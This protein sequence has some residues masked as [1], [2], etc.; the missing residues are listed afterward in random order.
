MENKSNVIPLLFESDSLVR[1]VM[2][3]GEI[4]FVAA[5]ICRVLGIQNVSQAVSRLNAHEVTALCTNEG[6]P[7]PAANIVS[8]PGVYRLVFTSRKPV[9]ER[10][11][12][13]LAHEVIPAIRKTGSF[14][15]GEPAATVIPPAAP[16]ESRFFPNWPMDE[17]RTK[18][19]VVDMYRMLYGVMAAQ[20]LAPQVGFPT[21][22]A[23]LVE[24][25]RQY[26]L[27]LVQTDEEEAA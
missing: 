27:T 6:S 1:T 14:S 5:D 21:P 11:K 17:L 23:K 13:W 19:G 26:T 18:R 16:T 4:W 20:W 15:T 24:H 12:R 22:P 8:E 10:L 2:Q 25:G 9:A 3:D 7:G